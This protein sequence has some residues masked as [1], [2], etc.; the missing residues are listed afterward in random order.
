MVRT[1]AAASSIASGSP[2]SRSTTR[3]TTSSGSETP[4]RA[5]RARWRNRSSAKSE[6]SCDKGNTCSAEMPSGARVVVTTRSVGHGRDQERHEVGDRSDHVLAVVEDQE[7]RGSFE[8]LGDAGADVSAA[9][10]AIRSRRELTE[11]RTPSAE[12]TSPTTSSGEA[13]PTSSTKCTTCCSAPRAS[14]CASLVLPRP[15]GAE[16]RDHTCLADQCAQRADV[17]VP[18]DQRRRVEA[19]ALAHRVV[20]GQQLAVHRPESGAR[21][22]AEP[23]G[24]VGAMALVAVQSGGSTAHRGLAAQQCGEGR[25]VA[26]SRLEERE[27]LVVVAEH[28]Q[29]PAEHARGDGQVSFGAGADA[30]PAG[31]CRPVRRARARAPRGPGRGQRRGRPCPPSGGRRR[32][33]RGGRA[34]RRPRRAVRGGSRGRCGRRRRARS[35]T[36]HGRRRPAAPCRGSPGRRP[37]RPRRRARPRRPRRAPP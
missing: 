11:S 21:I 17:L 18:P 12:P 6:S 30:R 20:G 26:R 16:D 32:P 3:S 8:L 36:A 15:P 27:R 5:A 1:L 14:T 37:P 4:G 7:R 25:V 23:V 31:R 34:R 24:Q 13:T 22:D 9:A 10:R 35:G 29:G 33:G 19:H 28:R 2:S